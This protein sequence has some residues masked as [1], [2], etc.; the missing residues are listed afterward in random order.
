MG[1]G[2]P[3]AMGLGQDSTSCHMCQTRLGFNKQGY[4]IVDDNVLLL[5]L[6]TEDWDAVVQAN[7]TD[8]ATLK[9][10]DRLSMSLLSRETALSSE[11]VLSSANVLSWASALSWVTGPSSIPS[12]VSLPTAPSTHPLQM[13]VHAA[14]NTHPPHPVR[15]QTRQMR[16]CACAGG[17]RETVDEEDATATHGRGW[18]LLH[19]QSPISALHF[20]VVAADTA[21]NEVELVNTINQ[22]VDSLA[23]FAVSMSFESLLNPSWLGIIQEHDVYGY[24][25]EP[26]E[27]Y[28][29]ELKSRRLVADV[30]KEMY[31][32]LGIEGT[33][34]NKTGSRYRI[35]FDLQD[36][37]IMTVGH[38]YRVRLLEN[39]SRVFKDPL[40]MKL[41]CS[42]TVFGLMAP[43]L[44]DV[45]MTA[46]TC[47][48]R[49]IDLPVPEISIS[50]ENIANSD[51]MEEWNL[52]LGSIVT[53]SNVLLDCNK[54]DP[55][56]SSCR[57]PDGPTHSITHIRLSG[58]ISPL[59]I[60]EIIESLPLNKS[61]C[62]VG[63]SLQGGFAMYLDSK[64]NYLLVTP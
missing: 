53:R 44:K 54:V 56:I 28:S 10:L 46:F 45:Q 4:T 63:Q 2:Q 1:L 52:W 50:E 24:F 23:A 42:A 6:V 35:D 58:L 8:V 57:L 20:V 31:E 59:Q 29:I 38:K 33:R 30:S 32:K 5:K 55:F 11:T 60:S 37:R 41:V 13:T 49:T 36:S 19:C 21:S 15:P 40:E 51:D 17:G 62:I 16:Q 3:F 34:L 26:R 9:L 43:H 25:Q 27:R 47:A 12:E 48:A 22:K 64:K 7:E 18:K 39:V 61:L 14:H